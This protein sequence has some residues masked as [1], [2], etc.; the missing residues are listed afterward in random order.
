MMDN[1]NLTLEEI[2]FLA[3]ILNTNEI[4]GFD[5]H[6]REIEFAKIDI[7]LIQTQ[8]DEKK[9]IKIISDRKIDIEQDIYLI[10]NIWNNP[11]TTLLFFNDIDS[12]D[13]PDEF[14]IITQQKAIDIR[15]SGENYQIRL[16]NELESVYSYLHQ[17]L[18]LNDYI[19][20]EDEFYLV[21][22]SD[23][24]E[25]KLENYHVY[26]NLSD[27]GLETYGIKKEQG[28]KILDLISKVSD[29]FLVMINHKNNEEL[30]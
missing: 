17:R 30:N 15:V 28:A 25:A 4:F 3:A 16:Y 12:N 26:K 14:L 1:Y 24:F 6:K 29:Y 22:S 19:K 18:T 5:F 10:F 7:N 20:S 9:Y 8:L 13:T 2:I 23:N 21:M 27:L 11:S